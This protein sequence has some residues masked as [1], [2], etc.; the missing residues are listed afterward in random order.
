M[1]EDETYELI[2]NIANKEGIF[3]YCH[4]EVYISMKNNCRDLEMKLLKSDIIKGS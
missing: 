3:K 4:V 2:I 1:I